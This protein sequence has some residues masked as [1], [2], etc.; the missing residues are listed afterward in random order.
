MTT[1]LPRLREAGA[2]EKC[3]D[4]RPR[5]QALATNLHQRGVYMPTSRY[6]SAQKSLGCCETATLTLGTSSAPVKVF[7]PK[8]GW[9]EWLGGMGEI[10]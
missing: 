4:V 1:A 7:H 3:C 10:D 2:A 5:L 6:I 9:V 8:D